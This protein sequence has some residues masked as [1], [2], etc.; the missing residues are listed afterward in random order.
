MIAIAVPR[1]VSFMAKK[2][3]FENKILGKLVSALN[4]FP[5]D[6]EGSDLSAI[7]NSLKVLKEDKVLGIFPENQSG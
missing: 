5:V 6:R 3:L 7:R 2:E 4:A 1:P